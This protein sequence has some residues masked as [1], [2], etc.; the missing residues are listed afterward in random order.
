LEQGSSVP[1]SANRVWVNALGCPVDGAFEAES[2]AGK[3]DIMR[4]AIIMRSKGVFF[5]RVFLQMF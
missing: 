5:M 4:R 1:S 2:D 3:A